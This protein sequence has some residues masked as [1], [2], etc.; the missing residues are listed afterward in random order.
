MNFAPE[1][2]DNHDGE[3]RRYFAYGPTL[4]GETARLALGDELVRAS[5]ETDER[6]EQVSA[7]PHTTRDT[8]RLIVGRAGRLEPGKPHI[9]FQVL[10]CETASNLGLR[11]A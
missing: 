10:T 8:L 6:Q 5:R 9:A 11:F 3:F 4:N 7:P 1:F 2:L